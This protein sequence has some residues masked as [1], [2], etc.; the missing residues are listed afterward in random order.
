MQA[1]GLPEH[2]HCC[3]LYIPLAAGLASMQR[4]EVDA[5][6]LWVAVL[7]Q[8][9]QA[10]KLDHGWGPTHDGDGGLSIG[11]QVFPHHILAHEAGA[12]LPLHALRYPVHCKCTGESVSHLQKVCLQCEGYYLG[13]CP[14][15]KSMQVRWSL[16]IRPWNTAPRMGQGSCSGR[17]IARLQDSQ[18]HP[19]RELKSVQ[20]KGMQA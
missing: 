5:G 11:E 16:R 1:A 8:V 10:G 9:G 4:L 17:G 18:T 20:N 19:G 15:L 12:I 6:L 2:R 13:S 7:A 14:S 3:A